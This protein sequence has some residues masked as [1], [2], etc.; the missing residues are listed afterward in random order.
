MKTIGLIGGMSWQSTIPSYRLVTAGW[1]CWRRAIPRR[2]RFIAIAC[3]I[4][5]AWK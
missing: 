3:M 4:A 2:S 5:T 1:V